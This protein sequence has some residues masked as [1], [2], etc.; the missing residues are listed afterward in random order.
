[1]IEAAEA[2]LPNAEQQPRLEFLRTPMEIRII[3][4]WTP[5]AGYGIC[6]D[7]GPAPSGTGGF[8]FS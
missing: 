7:H 1:M 3:E 2:V 5:A 4:T 6:L 8:P